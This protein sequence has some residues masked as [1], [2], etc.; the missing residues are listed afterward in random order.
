ME[1][2]RIRQLVAESE[3]ESIVIKAQAEENWR[4]GLKDAECFLA[5]SPSGI[6]VGELNEK[7]I[8]CILI[9]K[10]SDDFGY[11][12]SYIVW[13]EFR[14][15]GYGFAM[16]TAALER[17]KV[18]AIAGCALLELEKM[19][20]K[21]GARGH[22]YGGRYDFHIP[23]SM[24]CLSETSTGESVS[25]NVQ[26]FDKV[27]QEALFAYDSHVFGFP[28]HAFLNKWL[29]VSGS[30]SLVATDGDGAVVGYVTAR[31]TYVKE[32]GYRIGPLFADSSS[33]AEK[34]LK[35][36][37]EIL[38]HQEE[39]PSTI[40]MDSF[41]EEAQVL[42]RKL[43]GRKLIEMVYMTTSGT[44]PSGYFD[45]WFGHTSVEMG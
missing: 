38:L 39:G 8:G 20:H 23:T 37:F 17:V 5:C 33:I 7:P 3:V 27:N 32:D 2:F 11:V 43:Q 22:L 42:A 16:Y 44:L 1:G 29:Y 21:I 31:P 35:A 13:K 41:T 4:P 28:R 25:M 34:L 36:L 15:K 19:Y 24:R 40:C 10:Y 9:T 18:K 14:G 26:C 6:F 12:G 45:K 30:H